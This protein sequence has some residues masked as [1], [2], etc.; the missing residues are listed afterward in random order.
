MRGRLPMAAA[1]AAPHKLPMANAVE[2]SARVQP[3]SSLIGV[4]NT[5]STAPYIGVCANA[6]TVDAET[7]PQP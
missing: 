6:I 2:I 3:K 4:T 7:M 5:E 1:P